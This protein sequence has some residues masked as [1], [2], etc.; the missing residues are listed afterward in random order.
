MKRI[1]GSIPRA[2]ARI[3]TERAKS[4][5]I[6]R[7]NHQIIRATTARLA[8]IFSKFVTLINSPRK[9]EAIRMRAGLR[10]STPAKSFE[11]NSIS[12]LEAI[13]KKLTIPTSVIIAQEI[14]LGVIFFV[15]TPCRYGITETTAR[16]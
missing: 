1:V 11:D 4:T 6:S 12:G 8:A 13:A 5:E 15:Y 2:F 9:K 7:V 3:P 10:E 16:N 14:R